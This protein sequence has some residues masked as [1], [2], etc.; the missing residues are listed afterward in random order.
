MLSSPS[1]RDASASPRLELLGVPRFVGIDGTAVSLGPRVAPLVALIALGGATMRAEAASLLYPQLEPAEARRNLRQ[2]LHKQRLMLDAFIEHRGES[3]Q[4]RAQVHVDALAPAEQ[5]SASFDRP[6]SL[7]GDLRYDDLPE[8][9]AWLDGERGR[10]LLAWLDDLAGKAGQ[11]ER[12]GRLVEA[13]RSGERLA[14]EQP[15]SEHAHRRLMRLHYLRGDRAAALAAFDRCCDVLER[16]LGVAPEPETEALRARVEALSLPVSRESPVPLPVSVL[17]PPRLIGREREWQAMQADWAAGHATV[18]VGEAG[19]G[20]TRLVRDFSMGNSGTL[21]VD[22]RPGDARVPHALLSRLLRELHVRLSTPAPAGVVDELARLLPELGR[23]ATMPGAVDDTRFLNAVTALAQQA[24][25]EGLVGIL[26]D[27]LQFADA[28]S[29]DV[30]SHLVGA[31]LGLRWIVALRTVELEPE[32]KALHDALIAGD[33]ARAHRLL[34]LDEAQIAQLIDS[35]GIA[36]LDGIELAAPLARHTG[37]N[38]LFL[39]E[40]VKLLLASA[41]TRP[42]DLRSALDESKGGARGA[43]RGEGALPALIH[44]V[45]RLPSAGNVTRLIEQRISRLSSGAIRLARCA[46]VAGPDFS[47]E[48][49]AHVLGVRAL[50]FADAWAELDAAQVLHDGSF[51]HDLIYEAARQSVPA[52]IARQLHGEMAAFLEANAVEP[53]RVAQHWLDAGD[54]LRALPSLLAAADRA[55]AAWR[56]AEESRWL[57]RAAG[58]L[59]LKADDPAQAFSLLKRAHHA[60]QSAD[61]GSIAHRE[62]LADMLATAANQFERAEALA[63]RAKASNDLVELEA[64]LDDA[65]AALSLLRDEVGPS[66]D[67]LR[68]DIFSIQA[69]A[70]F[71][72]NLPEEAV[73]LMNECEAAVLRLNDAVRLTEHFGHLAMCLDGAGRYTEAESAHRRTLALTRAH[74]DRGREIT[75]LGNLSVSLAEVGRFSASRVPLLEA[76]RLREAY[77]EL[78]S[79]AVPLEYSLA[80]VTRCIGGYA[81]SLDWSTRA[82]KT[83]AGTMPNFLAAVLNHLA[84]TWLHLGQHGRAGQRL[85]EALAIAE[86]APPAYRAA[87]HVTLARSA[88]GQG[89]PRTAEAALDV[90]RPLIGDAGR[91]GPRAKFA[92]MEAAIA[93]PDVGYAAASAVALEAGRRDARGLRMAALAYAAR[94]ALACGHVAVGVAHAVEALALW[95]EHVPDDFYIGEVWLI[96]YECLHAAGDARRDPMLRTAAEWIEATARERVPREFQESFRH[97]NTHNRDLLA[98]AARLL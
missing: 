79:V 29:V 68:L 41:A 96:C 91:Y 26:V 90:A 66:A 82:L 4:I 80:D 47:S 44:V 59:R 42:T 87:I 63:L 69:L 75:V 2:L 74:G 77:P 12:E 45:G 17:R 85:Q 92:L 46:A 31:G 73:K 83:V 36:E 27:D 15:T 24:Q 13:L 53:A 11:D 86:N 3:M 60:H 7:L 38:P 34:P 78:R 8:L 16:S 65:K 25:S 93:E 37:G 98:A 43:E 6:L 51:A 67:A 10:R 84:L 71:N 20:K 49:A 39:L 23:A 97:R 14:L 21:W 5:A 81:E 62:V 48:L 54:E 35:L 52:P 76:W 88:L 57:R 72:S 33:G 61:I 94:C 28:A 22:A 95:P 50:D 19:M 58:I 40:T 18:I 32:A 30:L 64:S 55:G 9:Q 56:S 89:K 1:L 70:L